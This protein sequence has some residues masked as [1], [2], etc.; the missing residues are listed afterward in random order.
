MTGRVKDSLVPFLE[1][2]QVAGSIVAADIAADAVT[3]AKILN[4][5]VTAA[6]LASDAVE[7][8][9][10]KD[11]NV[12]TG[13]LAANAVTGPKLASGAFLSTVVTG[14]NGAGACT[15]TG[16]K[17]GDKVLMNVNISDATDAQADFE[18][19]ITVVDQ[20]QQSSASD[21]STKK[22]AV[23]LLVQS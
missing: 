17:I 7:T 12:T 3:T 20:I 14:H 19:T 8:A 10:I 13:K 2:S 15:L 18:A 9:K 22:F 16:A 21:L 5:N 6:K 1:H 23:L 4:A 11:L